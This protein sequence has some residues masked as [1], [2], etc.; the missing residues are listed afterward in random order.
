MSQTLA[1]RRAKDSLGKIQSLEAE[2]KEKY[3]KYKSY[4]DGLP[5]SILMNGL[6]Q[7]T[8]TLLAQAKGNKRDPHRILYEHLSGWLCGSDPDTPYET[9]QGK[10]A[11]DYLMTAI[12][13][14]NTGEQV[15]L[16]AQAEAMAYLEWLKK[17]A[18]A[19]LKD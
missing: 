16:H 19:Y 6:G 11:E 17:F 1:Q 3:G 14:Q 12:T 8:A 15:Y 4:V 10:D 5:A 13:D 9:P 2:G 7:A 18:N